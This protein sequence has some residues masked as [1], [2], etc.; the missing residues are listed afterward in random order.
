ME[1][2]NSDSSDCSLGVAPLRVQ[3][4]RE[5]SG[6]ILGKADAAEAIRKAC[7]VTDD[8]NELADDLA[9]ALIQSVSKDGRYARCESIHARG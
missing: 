9:S 5:A 8:V 1:M 4:G 6:S 7:G 2:Q 3:G